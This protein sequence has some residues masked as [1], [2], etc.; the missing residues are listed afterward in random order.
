M[1]RLAIYGAAAVAALF[2]LV[3]VIAVFFMGS[4]T[5]KSEASFTIPAGSSLTAV[6]SKLEEAGHISSAS[7]FT[8]RAK[9]IGGSQPIQAGEFLLN[10]EMDQGDILDAFQNGDVIRRFV[11]IPE[12]MPSVLVLERLMAEEMLVGE[13]DV[14][15]EVS[16]IHI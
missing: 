2:A 4:A 5:I 10:P 12:G 11:T 13:P 9:L 16:L 15:V 1:A 3:L 14:P 8:L 7:G 6:A